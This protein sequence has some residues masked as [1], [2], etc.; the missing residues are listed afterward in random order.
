MYFKIKVY[1]Q[2][3][4]DNMGELFP[5]KSKYGVAYPPLFGHVGVFLIQ[6]VSQFF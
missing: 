3:V 6:S 2:L 1:H 5:Y 4:G